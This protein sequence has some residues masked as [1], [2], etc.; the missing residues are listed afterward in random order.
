MWKCPRCENEIDNLD[1]SVQTREWGCVNL[2][3]PEDENSQCDTE[4]Y[5]SNDSEW[6]GDTSF[7]CPECSND[8]ELDELIPV[9]NEEEKKEDNK[10][11][12]EKFN[13]IAP[14]RNLQVKRENIS[15]HTESIMICK[16]CL[17][18]F[19][20]SNEK[21]GDNEDE[22]FDCPQCG[23]QNNKKE[24]QE[25][26]QSRYYEK[27]KIKRIKKHAKKTKSRRLQPVDRAGRSVCFTI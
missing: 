17:H 14:T 1:Y 21:Y 4:N 15:N 9:I 19:V 20:Y 5:E 23:L 13:I 25:R 3:E 12:E 27:I 2:S 18:A 6:T 8:I 11:E 10:L 24:Y 22:F 7:S 16:H 26:I